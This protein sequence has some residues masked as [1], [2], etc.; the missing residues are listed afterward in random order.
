MLYVWRTAEIYHV[1]SKINMRGMSFFQLDCVD[2]D[3]VKIQD[4]LDKTHFKII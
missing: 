4:R 1:F 2:F 3:T